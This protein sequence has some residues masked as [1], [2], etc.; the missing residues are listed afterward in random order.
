[1][2]RYPVKPRT[3]EASR[4]VIVLGK[5]FLAVGLLGSLLFAHGCHGPDDDHELFAALAR[6]KT[7]VCASLE[8]RSGH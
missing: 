8:L 6:V 5:W 1:M 7:H 3:A 4:F 2:T